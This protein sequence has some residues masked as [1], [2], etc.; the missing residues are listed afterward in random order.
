[1]TKGLLREPSLIRMDRFRAFKLAIFRLISVIGVLALS[2]K[3]TRCFVFQTISLLG[4][5]R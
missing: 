1:M 3:S 2:A 4:V 5:D